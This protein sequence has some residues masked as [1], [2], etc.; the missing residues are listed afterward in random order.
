MHQPTE[1]LCAEHDKRISLTEQAVMS[2]KNTNEGITTKLDL[3]LAQMTKVA[4]LEEKHQTHALDIDRANNKIS[5]NE[6]EL[7]ELAI[8]VRHFI[9][10]SQGRDKILWAIGS[11]VLALVIKAVFFAAQL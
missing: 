7:D 8:E 4:L 5:S 6:K 11:A 2:L 3:L 1:R 10:Y 9:S